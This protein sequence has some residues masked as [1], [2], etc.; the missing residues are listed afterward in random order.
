VKTGSRII[1]FENFGRGLV[2]MPGPEENQGLLQAFGVSADPHGQGVRLQM[3]MSALTATWPSATANTTRQYNKVVFYGQGVDVAMVRGQTKVWTVDFG[4]T[5]TNITGAVVLGTASANQ[6]NDITFGA[7]SGG[8]GPMYSPEGWQWTGSGNIAAWTTTSGTKPNGLPMV[9]WENKMWGTDFASTL[10]FSD[11][12]DPRSWPATG[13]VKIGAND[14]GDIT[15]LAIYG[16]YLMVFKQT[17]IYLVYDSETGANRQ[18][19]SQHGV[20]ATSKESVQSSPYGVFFWDTS[21]V[22]MLADA[23]TVKPLTSANDAFFRGH[24][25]IVTAGGYHDNWYEVSL[26]AGLSFNRHYRYHIP[27]STWWQTP[28]NVTNGNSPASFYNARRTTGQSVMLMLVQDEGTSKPA[29]LGTGNSA[30]GA[31]NLDSGFLTITIQTSNMTFAG[32]MPRSRIRGVTVRTGFTN[33][34]TLTFK[35]QNGVTLWT[36]TVTP[37]NGMIRVTGLGSAAMARAGSLTITV[38]STAGG[39]NTT[40]QAINSIEFEV[41]GRND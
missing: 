8:Q 10:L 1:K 7:P 33:A 24:G 3:G 15:A 5:A 40:N 28:L 12:G 17:G 26:Q 39:P 25:A 22:V 21:G 32:P 35:D 9:W 11:I 16:P 41:W 37:S 30:L 14:G 19:S 31:G 27:T 4:G 13:F 34:H 23:T 38:T 18:I 20:L 29:I 6:V 2:T 36:R